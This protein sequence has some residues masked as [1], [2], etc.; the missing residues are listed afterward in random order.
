LSDTLR[1][2]RAVMVRLTV[3][4]RSSHTCR[5]AAR[6]PGARVRANSARF[7][8]TWSSGSLRRI[9]SLACL[10]PAHGLCSQ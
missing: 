5:R 1:T 3:K 10:S 6:R 7:L 4:L 9:G 8:S 2:P